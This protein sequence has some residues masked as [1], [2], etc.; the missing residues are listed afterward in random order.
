MPLPKFT[1]DQANLFL[2]LCDLLS[3]FI[4]QHSFRSQIFLFTSKLHLRVASLLRAKDKHVRLGAPRTYDDPIRA[5]NR[6]AFAA[7][8]R[9][10]RACMRIDNPKINMMFDEQDVFQPILEFTLWESRRDNLLSSAAQELFDFI[11][12]VSLRAH[13]VRKVCRTADCGRCRR[14]ERMSSAVSLHDIRAL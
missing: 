12:R 7:A 5:T 9:F 11:R 6:I 10:F 1:N 4:L 14:I 3:A 13:F 2:Y 8:V